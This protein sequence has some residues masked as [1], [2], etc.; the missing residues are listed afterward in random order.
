[1]SLR[2]ALLGLTAALPSTGYE[3]TRLFDRSLAY[4]W[5]ASHSQIYPELSKLEEEGLVEVVNEGPRGSRTFAT[6]DAGRDALRAW[7]VDVAP[8]RKVRDETALR[9]FLTSLLEPADRRVVLERELAL[10]EE[11][12]RALRELAAR[13]DELVKQDRPPGFRPMID[14]GLRTLPVTAAWL[15]DQIEATDR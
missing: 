3:L 2:Y 10:V 14:L 8:N 12:A 13:S 9:L 7:L 6:T 1:M 11:R 5:H 4:A 15:R